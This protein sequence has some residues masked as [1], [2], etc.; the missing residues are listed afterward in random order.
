MKAANE[1]IEDALAATKGLN[2]I[3]PTWFSVTDNSGNISSI[4]STDYVDYAHQCGLEVWALVDNFDQNVDDMELAQ[5]YFKQ[6]EPGESA[7]KCSTSE[8]N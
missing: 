2:T 6:G 5:S 4:A 7:G 3:S 8:W 1:G